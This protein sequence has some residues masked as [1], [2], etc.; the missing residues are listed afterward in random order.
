MSPLR[1]VAATTGTGAPPPRGT[2]A[3]AVAP[4]R[5]GH[6]KYADAPDTTRATT[7]AQGQRPR[8]VLI[9]GGRARSVVGGVTG[10]GTGS[11]GVPGLS[12]T[13]FVVRSVMMASARESGVQKRTLVRTQSIARE[14]A[15][16]R[17]ASTA[18]LQAAHTS[19]WAFRLLCENALLSATTARGMPRCRPALAVRNARIFYDC[20]GMVA[21]HRRKCHGSHWRERCW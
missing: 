7:T 12:S 2:A 5:R 14:H 10:A 16:Q 11:T 15:L 9:V 1:A 20:G 8:T 13:G 4:V 3:L 21:R 18:V 6:R 17:L 19:R